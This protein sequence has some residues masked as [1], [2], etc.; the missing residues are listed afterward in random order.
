VVSANRL[1]FRTSGERARLTVV[2]VGGRCAVLD[3]H[4][5]VIGDYDAEAAVRVCAADMDRLDEP[6]PDELRSP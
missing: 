5:V 2:S 6:G 3:E 4:G 1:W